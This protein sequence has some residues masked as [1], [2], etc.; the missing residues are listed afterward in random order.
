MGKKPTLV[1]CDFDGTIT[2]KDSFGEFI[3][4][5]H[6][7]PTYWFGLLLHFPI[8]VLYMLG[9]YNNSKAKEKL[10][11]FYFKG[12]DDKQFNEKSQQFAQYIIPKIVLED[13]F[14]KLLEYKALGYEIAIVSASFANYLEPWCNENGFALIATQLEVVDGAVSG[15]IK[16]N[17]CH[18]EEKVIRIKERYQ[19]SNYYIIAY[20]DTKGDLPMLKLAKEAYYKEFKK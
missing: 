9:F 11:T 12:V 19:L 20:G 8:L 7:T 5:Y 17:N 14:T 10:I 16:G 3:K 1:L 18:G 2:S 4:F 6:G 15:K 13:A